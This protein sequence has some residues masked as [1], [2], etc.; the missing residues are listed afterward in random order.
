MSRAVLLA[1]VVFAY[2]LLGA[3]TAG[4]AVRFGLEQRESDGVGM[5]ALMWPFVWAI[6][7]VYAICLP[8]RSVYRVVAGQRQ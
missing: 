5:W 3:V 7:A 1:A 8:F 2:V 4:L 6:G